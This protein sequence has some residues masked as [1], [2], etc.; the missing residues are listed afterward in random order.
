MSAQPIGD[1]VRERRRA[2]ESASG[3]DEPEGSSSLQATAASEQLSGRNSPYHCLRN[4]SRSGSSVSSSAS[5][6]MPREDPGDLADNSPWNA[7][8]NLVPVSPTRAPRPSYPPFSRA[9]PSLHSATSSCPS[10]PSTF[11]FRSRTSS[12]YTSRSQS[13]GHLR[14]SSDSSLDE[15]KHGVA[16]GDNPESLKAAYLGNL[17]PPSPASVGGRALSQVF[18]SLED[19][20]EI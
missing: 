1:L 8:P 17:P 11:S 10:S 13:S 15:A 5:L 18:R 14:Q 12:S 16:P 19:L 6:P 3:P 4:E 9:H 7:S 2:S 20:L